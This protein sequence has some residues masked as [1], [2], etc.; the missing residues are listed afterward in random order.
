MKAEARP[1]RTE[2]DYNAAL[3]E[4]ERLMNSRPGTPDGDRFEMLVTGIEAYEAQQWKIP[5]PIPDT[6][7]SGLDT[8]AA[9]PLA[10]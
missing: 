2:D 1:I 9:G 3:V 6:T 8:P 7:D 10:R 5:S 4:A